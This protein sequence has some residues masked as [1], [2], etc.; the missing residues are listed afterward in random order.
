[1]W[2]EGCQHNHLATNSH[3]S[4][5]LSPLWGACSVPHGTPRLAQGWTCTESATG[6]TVQG[7]M[8]AVCAEAF[9]G[10]LVSWGA[11]RDT[12]PMEAHGTMGLEGE[13][14]ILELF[15]ALSQSEWGHRQISRLLQGDQGCFHTS[16]IFLWGGFTTPISDHPRQEPVEGN[17]LITLWP[18][19]SAVMLLR[20]RQVCKAPPPNSKHCD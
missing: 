14:R 11:P 16:I 8:T 5:A 15:H 1:M 20:V 4:L 17:T 6:L 9:W 13:I 19:Q 10:F 2:W 18:I 7:G 3:C 12:P